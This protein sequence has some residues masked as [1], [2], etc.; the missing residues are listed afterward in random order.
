MLNKTCFPLYNKF[1]PKVPIFQISNGNK[2]TIHRFFDTSPVS[3]SGKYITLTEFNDDTSLPSLGDFAF[4]IVID[5]NSGEEVYRKK[6]YAWDTQ[7]GA[8]AQWGAVDEELFFNDMDIVSW[9]PYGIKVNILT[10]AECVLKGTIYMVSPDGKSSLTPCLKKIGY[11]QKGYGV[12]VPTSKVELEPGL[13]ESDG[14]FIIDN[15]TGNKQLLLNIKQITSSIFTEKE[16]LKMAKGYFFCFHLK[17]NPQ[18]TKIMLLLRWLNSI[19]TKKSKNFLIT[20][21]SD[22]SDIKLVVSPKRWGQGHHPNWCPDGKNIIMNLTFDDYRYVVPSFVNFC[23]RVA[24]KLGVRLY[25]NARALRLSMFR[26]DSDSFNNIGGQYY[27]SGHPTFNEKGNY[28]LTDSYPSERVAFSDGTVP[29]R[30][31]KFGGSS[32]DTIVRV[33]TKPSYNGPK[34]EWRIDPHPAWNHNHRYFVFN[35]APDGIRQVF[36]ADMVNYS[37]K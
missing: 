17:W 11:I 23:E 32:E 31:V 33:A 37:F 28:S 5:L 22:G 13:S 24:R 15:S 6:T 19:E 14:V 35:A 18:G 1:S 20:F 34:G 9:H 3:P 25:T 7:L 10:G 29:I 26:F 16:L 21:N 36:I 12:N 8:Q 4:V 2:P 30:A 27:G